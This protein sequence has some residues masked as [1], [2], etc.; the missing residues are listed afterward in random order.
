MNWIRYEIL[1]LLRSKLSVMALVFLFALVSTS[2]WFGVQEVQ[3][4]QQ[5][6]HELQPLHE[7][8][9]GLLIDQFKQYPEGGDAGTAAYYTFYYTWNTP[10]DL[11]FTAVGLRDVAPYVLRIRALA[12]QA[13]LYDGDAF[14]PEFVLSGRFDFAFVL[15]YLVPLFIIALMHDLVSSEHQSGRLTLLHSLPQ[16]NNKRWI[17]RILLR[18]TLVLLTLLTPFAVG[19]IVPQATVAATLSFMLIIISYCAFWFGI[20]TF[21]IKMVWCSVTNATLLVGIWIIVTLILPTLTNLVIVRYVP[22]AQGVDLILT[23]RQNT[24]SAWEIPREQTMNNF[25]EYHPQWQDTAPLPPDFHWK[26]YF[27]FHQIADESVEDLFKQYR[28]DLYQR[29]QLT[30]YLGWILPSVGAQ[31]AIHRL[32]NTDLAA[33]LDYQDQIIAFHQQIRDFYYPY[34]F[35]D[36]PFTVADF[37]RQPVFHESINAPSKISRENIPFIL[38]SL[39]IF[40]I[41]LLT[42]NLKSNKH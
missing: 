24:H 20:C 38:L 17:K 42:F 11:A 3:Y 15:I 13:Q 21:V 23:Q 5:T 6:I 26:W 7:Q 9:V 37:V 41:S 14:N 40:A 4:Q 29:Q 22:V 33:Q 1:L 8:D 32:A 27:A 10:S 28:A 25:F 16:F 34:L 36:L 18:F 2:V 35:N 12:L 30:H 19:A 39:I 31:T